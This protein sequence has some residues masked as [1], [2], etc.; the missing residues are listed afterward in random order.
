MSL[1]FQPNYYLY[2]VCVDLFCKMYKFWHDTNMTNQYKLS[3]KYHAYSIRFLF[4]KFIFLSSKIVISKIW[5]LKWK[6]KELS[7][8]L[9]PFQSNIYSINTYY[10]KLKIVNHII[11]FVKKGKNERNK[12]NFYFLFFILIKYF[13]GNDMGRVITYLIQLTLSRSCLT[14]T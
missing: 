2:R 3:Y 8:F 4:T 6:I 9:L 14:L 11:E 5:Q 7:N 1:F 12:K 13:P 10:F